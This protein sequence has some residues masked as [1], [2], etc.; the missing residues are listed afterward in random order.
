MLPVCI[1]FFSQDSFG[2]SVFSLLGNFTIILLESIHKSFFNFHRSMIVLSS[3]NCYRKPSSQW[4]NVDDDCSFVLPRVFPAS[5]YLLM[6]LI[7]TI[8]ELSTTITL[9]LQIRKLSTEKYNIFFFVIL[10]IASACSL[11]ISRQLPCHFQC[12]NFIIN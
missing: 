7:L 6:H 5:L 11:S 9:I 2:I 3:W 12:Y 4:Q 1:F 8:T 10:L